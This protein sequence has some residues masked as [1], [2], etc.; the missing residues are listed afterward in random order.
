MINDILQEIIDQVQA[1]T[2]APVVSATDPK[3]KTLSDHYRVT[4]I[5]GEPVQESELLYPRAVHENGEPDGKR[6]RVGELVPC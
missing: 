2:L 3:G 6:E 1:Q 4:I 5:P